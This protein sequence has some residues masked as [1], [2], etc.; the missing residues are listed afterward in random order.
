MRLAD[1]VTGA[2]GTIWAAKLRT[3]LT[4]LGIIIGVASVVLVLSIGAGVKATITGSFSNLG[5]TR[6]T[7]QPSAPGG[8]TDTG[9]VGV[10][11]MPPRSPVP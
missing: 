3:F 4:A 9:Q 8:G 1:Y 2:L 11:L 6:I 5:S 7:I 10:G